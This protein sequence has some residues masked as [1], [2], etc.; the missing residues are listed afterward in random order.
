MQKFEYRTPRFPA[1]FPVSFF[2]GDHRISGRSTDLSAVGMGAKFDEPVAV[3][4]LGI[5][6]LTLGGQSLELNARIAYSDPTHTGVVFLFTSE[7]ER[8][9]LQEFIAAVAQPRRS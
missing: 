3:G 4:T 8:E 2:G 1:D 9:L 7:A 6:L 5:L